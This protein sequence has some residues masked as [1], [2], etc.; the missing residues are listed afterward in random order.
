MATSTHSSDP[1]PADM[2]ELASLEDWVAQHLPEENREN[3][4]E[5][6][7]KLVLIEEILAQGQIAPDDPQRA[8]KLRCLGAA[9]GAAL[10]QYYGGLKWMAYEDKLGHDLC[11]QFED[12]PIRLFPLAMISKRVAAGEAVDVR[13]MFIG[14]CET[15]DEIRE[16]GQE[17][18]E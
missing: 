10:V 18:S 7:A 14:T 2:A 13:E 5:L 16:G 8:L 9:F 17:A 4:G 1:T 6:A 3:Y 11:L 12:T 15:L